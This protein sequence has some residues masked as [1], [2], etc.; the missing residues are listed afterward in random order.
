MRPR[1]TEP[2]TPS[3]SVALYERQARAVAAAMERTGQ[4]QSEVMRRWLTT[5]A[6]IDG[7]LPPGTPATPPPLNPKQ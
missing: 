1:R 7:Y 6:V 5:G 4:S 2:S 3:R